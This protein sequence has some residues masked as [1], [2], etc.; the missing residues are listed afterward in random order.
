MNS[1]VRHGTLLAAMFVVTAVIV[2]IETGHLKSGLTV[3]AIA[4]P[5]KFAVASLHAKLFGRH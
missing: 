1:L 5:I 4:G 3:G 2:T